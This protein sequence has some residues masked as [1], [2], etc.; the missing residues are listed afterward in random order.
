VGSTSSEPVAVRRRNVPPVSPPTV[1]SYS[2]MFHAPVQ[3]ATLPI[4]D[5][6]SDGQRIEKMIFLPS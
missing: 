4:F 6:L 5:V 2:Q 3:A 1:M